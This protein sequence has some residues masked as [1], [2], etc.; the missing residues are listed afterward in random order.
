MGTPLGR[1]CTQAGAPG[2]WAGL[3]TPV[4]FNLLLTLTVTPLPLLLFLPLLLHPL[5]L[6]PEP[7]IQGLLPLLLLPQLFLLLHPPCQGSAGPEPGQRPLPPHPSPAQGSEDS[8]VSPMGG[9]PKGLILSVAGS[10][11]DA[12]M[13]L[14]GGT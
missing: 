4:L 10:M 8:G 3:D 14:K 9:R 5:L 2:P 7:L 6:E 12:D 1:A 13:L 11:R